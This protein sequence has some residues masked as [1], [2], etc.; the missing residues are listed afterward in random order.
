[1]L[2]AGYIQDVCLTQWYQAGVWRSVVD[3]GIPF[4]HRDLCGSLARQLMLRTTPLLLFL[5]RS[6]KDTSVL[7]FCIEAHHPQHDWAGKTHHMRSSVL[8]MLT[9]NTIL[10]PGRESDGLPKV[11]YAAAANLQRLAAQ[12]PF[13]R[14][15]HVHMQNVPPEC[16]GQTK[17]S[18]CGW[19]KFLDPE[20]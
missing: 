7:P 15:N 2:S 5:M 13:V 4:M 3:T 19:P 17:K 18:L 20:F 6:V 9:G 1:M 11:A 10:H 12:R 16:S 8:K 14:S